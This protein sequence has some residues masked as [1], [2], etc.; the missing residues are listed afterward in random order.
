MNKLV[1]LL[2]GVLSLTSCQDEVLTEKLNPTQ[3]TTLEEKPEGMQRLIVASRSNLSELIKNVGASKTPMTRA[4]LK[5]LK[6]EFSENKEEYTSLYEAN[7]A[8]V[9][10]SL[11]DEQKLEIENDEDGLEFC[12][13]DS[14]IADMRFTQLLNA[15]REIQV[16]DTIYKYVPKGVA[17]TLV[18]H[19]KELAKVEEW[20]KDVELTPKTIGKEIALSPNTK[21]VPMDYMPYP[22]TDYKVDAYGNPVFDETPKP[23]SPSVTPNDSPTATYTPE[24]IKLKN[25]T[26]I[27]TKDIREI[28]YYDKGDANWLHRIITGCFGRNVVAVNKFSSDKRL[29]L[30]FYDQNYIIYSNIGTELNMQKKKF[31]LWWNIKAEELVQG[32][33][34]ITLKYDFKQPALNYFTVNPFTKKVE[35]PSL[36]KNPFPFQDES[37]VLLHIP[38]VNYDFTMKDLNKA[39]QNG[40]K[41]AINSGTEWAKNRIN[42]MPKD[43]VGLFTSEGKSI[44]VIFG[45]FSTKAYNKRTLE[46]KVFAKWFP[47]TYQVGFSFGNSFKVQGIDMDG[48]D[49]VTLFRG[50]VFGAIKY[51][52]KW[53]A[54]RIIKDTHKD[55]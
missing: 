36:F 20:T 14:V 6:L 39:F 30:N 47:G 35:A 18:K 52:G 3:Q 40:M 19:E 11:T 22:I 9:M 2:A 10:A 48:N 29:R 5:L 43:K 15:E 32:W 8:K 27:P 17:F 13:T 42:G 51:K 31:Y 46:T 1:F 24:G 50:S 23:T 38:F 21:F 41:S 53:L 34:T 37:E 49:N 7:R 26:L 25:G 33:E 44:Y 16:A 28:N 55:D 45:S 54:A 4:T 12:P